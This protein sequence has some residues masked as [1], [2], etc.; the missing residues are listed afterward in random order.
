VQSQATTPRLASKKRNKGV[1][2]LEGSGQGTKQPSP[3]AA[4]ILV[5]CASIAAWA[6]HR[7]WALR[8]IPVLVPVVSTPSPESHP[9]PIRIKARQRSQLVSL[10]RPW[11][12]VCPRELSVPGR[13]HDGEAQDAWLPFG[14]TPLVAHDRGVSVPLTGGE[15][16]GVGRRGANQKRRARSHPPLAAPHVCPR[17][18]HAANARVT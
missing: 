3:H 1:T 14:A 5:R 8:R 16:V 18:P 15:S 9:S 6:S 13:V 2:Y 17:I 11:H 4:V 12:N 10:R 7:V